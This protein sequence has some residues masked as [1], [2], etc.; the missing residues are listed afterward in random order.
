MDIAHAQA[1]HLPFFALPKQRPL[2]GFNGNIETY[3]THYTRTSMNI[4]GHVDKSMF[5]FLTR[6]EHYAVILG[7]PWL[8]KH[9]PRM[10]FL[11][12]S[13]TFD[14]SFCQT[15][16][17]FGTPRAR[18]DH[19]TPINHRKTHGIPLHRADG[20]ELYPR[21]R[22]IFTRPKTL[23]PIPTVEEDSG[24]ESESPTPPLTQKPQPLSIAQIGAA[25][26]IS[27]ARKKG[28]QLFTLS[29]R[30][31]DLALNPT[32]DL[33][34]CKVTAG[35]LRKKEDL[36]KNLDP[37]TIVPTEYHDRISAFS[38]ANS[39]LL[40]P[41]R[42]SD[43]RIKL[44]E[45]ATAPS[46]PLYPMSRDQ[47]EVLR[48]YLQDNLT[49]G[50]IRASQSP[51]SSPVLFVKKSDG[52]LRFCVDYRALNALTVKNRYPLPLIS[53]T[54]QK[55]SKAVIYT[56]LDIIAAF[57]RLRMAKGDEWMTA[58]AC[59]YGLYE[60]TVMPFGLCNGPASF[61]GYIN[62]ILSDSLFEFCTA[63]LD[64]ILIFSSSRE[65]HV[66]HV[67]R[68]LDRLI[69]A[70]LQVDVTKC[71]FH[72]TEV[73]YR[74]LIVTTSGVRMDPKKVETI[75]NWETPSNVKDVQ[76]FL[77]FANFYR[78][79]IP[80]FSAVASPLTALTKKD[81]PFRWTP[82]ATSAFE[83]LKAE[84]I[85]QPILAHFDPDL[86]IVLETDASD[87]VAAGVLSQWGKDGLLHPVAFYS[88]K[89]TP[90]ECNYEIYDKELGAIVKAFELWRAELQ[91]S[92]F[93]I[94]ILT[95]HKNL[96]YFM[97]TKNLS[98]RQTRWSEYLSRFDFL[99][100]YRAGK[101]GQK[102]DSL[103][104][105]S[106]DLPKGGDE[107][108][109]YQF[110]TVLKQRNLAPEIQRD[111]TPE[112][113][114]NLAPENH[115]LLDPEAV[116]LCPVHINDDEDDRTLPQL[117]EEAYNNDTLEKETLALLQEPGTQRS[118][119]ISLTE[120]QEIQGHL[121]YRDRRYVPEY[122]PLR[123]RLLSLHHDILSSGHRGRERTYENISRSYW[124]PD[125]VADV[126]R[127]VRNCHLCSMIKSSRE[128]YQGV[129]KPLPVPEHR[130]KH[131]SMD[132][133]VGLPASRYR[134]ELVTNIL[135][136]VDRLTKKKR[137]LPCA[138][139]SAESVADLFYDNVWRHDG[140]PLSI[141]SDR[142]TNFVS[143]FFQ[144]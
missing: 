6:L 25:P 30:D 10:D 128:K 48:D 87:Y 47:S 100:K 91:G 67:R 58:F 38:R 31:L 39:E 127:Y 74:G 88:S 5:F 143:T 133:I 63:Y 51:A 109:Q 26:F 123:K 97:T 35:E 129:L 111:L 82:E 66:V 118:K 12:F 113:Q 95:D 104:R 139:M 50:F 103:T 75:K 119:R 92:K 57:N 115:E 136:I 90:A 116:D 73:H 37:K 86:Q 69:E 3:V 7:L 18:L 29:L 65:E 137:F 70:G 72:A 44:K 122:A 80:R 15:N 59:Q 108:I 36:K 138:N 142:G 106:G 81:K 121:Y 98:R 49:K 14:S 28:N 27:L 101:Q 40:P 4:N 45:G 43:H 120:C 76:S 68:V 84:F 131:L 34:L 64:D 46:G 23:P 52:G 2:R 62:H 102:P 21:I 54:L 33:S 17:C 24:Y 117:W 114:R 132:F 22:S 42:P 105:R 9:N 124:W 60:Y 20:P 112:V 110:Q 11:D 32:R 126:A 19:V 130:G 107:R 83:R 71:E 125:M 134:G 99:I 1:H 13:L 78:R 96:E 53:E 141:I 41:H 61:Q 16:C 135:V 55:L 140:T 77:G 144:H 56:K 93:P 94:E 89:H 85:K 8:R 79:F